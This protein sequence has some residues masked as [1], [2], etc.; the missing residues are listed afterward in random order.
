MYNPH[1]RGLAI[2]GK[3]NY[4]QMTDAQLKRALKKEVA[5]FEALPR[6]DSYSGLGI[7]GKINSIQQEMY[8]RDMTWDQYIAEINIEVG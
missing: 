5:A 8:R 3:M 6:S 7:S 4:Q 1:P 2:G